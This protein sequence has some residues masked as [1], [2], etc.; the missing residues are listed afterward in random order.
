MV[1]KLSTLSEKFNFNQEDRIPDDQFNVVLW[2]AVHGLN[3]S[4]PAPVHA[5][6][7]ASAKDHEKD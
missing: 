4:C 7:F 6:F 3:S 2:G 1:N 5:A